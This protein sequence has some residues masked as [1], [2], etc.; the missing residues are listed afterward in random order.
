V[1][2]LAVA[3]ALQESVELADKGALEA[4][5]DFALALALGDAAAGGGPGWPMMVWRSITMVGKARF[6]CRSHP[7]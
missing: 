1:L 7:G 6:S 2:L 3:G 4:A 5:A